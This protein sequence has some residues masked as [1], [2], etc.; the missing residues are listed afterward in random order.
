MGDSAPVTLEWDETV[1]LAPDVEQLMDDS[2][3]DQLEIEVPEEAIE[4]EEQK[5][6][7]WWAN[8]MG[9]M[10]I[11]ILQEALVKCQPRD[12]SKF[13]YTSDLGK[14][15]GEAEDSEQKGAEES[16]GMSDA[17][18][19]MYYEWECQKEK[20]GRSYRHSLE[21]KQRICGLKGAG[22]QP[23]DPKVMDWMNR[24]KAK[25]G[26]QLHTVL[27]TTGAAFSYLEKSGKPLLIFTYGPLR[28]MQMDASQIASQKL[29]RFRGAHQY[30]YI[31]TLV[32]CFTK[33][34]WV[35]AL[36]PLAHFL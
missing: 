10:T 4:E 36:K 33:Q 3:D 6:P 24:K 25:F 22:A 34:A 11:P 12:C 9:A 35:W 1:L 23:D 7:D 21:F 13:L 27:T 8:P 19:A 16:R 29:K 17:L 5:V 30:R 15:E 28:R 26:C 31:L 18:Y 20:F 32:D 2:R 14:E